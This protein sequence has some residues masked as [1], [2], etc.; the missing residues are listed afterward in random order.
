MN[1]GVEVLIQEKAETHCFET[2]FRDR[3]FASHKVVM[4]LPLIA[5]ALT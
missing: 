1:Q 5:A 2:P 4:L 3:S